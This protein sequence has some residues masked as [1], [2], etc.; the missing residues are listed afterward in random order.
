MPTTEQQQP[1][2]AVIAWMRADPDR[3]GAA[4]VLAGLGLIN[5]AGSATHV[6]QVGAYPDVGVR[7][8]MVW[9]VAG[10]L[11]VLA[12]YAAWEMR[13]R[14]DWRRIIPALVLLLAVAFII[15]ANLAAADPHSWAAQLPWAEAFAVAPPISFL[16]VAAIAETRGWQRAGRRPRTATARQRPEEP[17]ATTRQRRQATRG[18]PTDARP[19]PPARGRP[20]RSADDHG[21]QSLTVEPSD[22]DR[23]HTIL[24]WLSQGHDEKTIRSRGPAILGVSESTIKRELRGVSARDTDHRDRPSDRRP[25]PINASAA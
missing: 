17:K 4:V 11:E 6:L 7:G 15:L 10:S 5:L 24:R 18:A 14:S 8:W 3:T 16:S 22:K 9:T 1:L 19:S 23:T 25:E 21:P 12:A 13:R 20:R 2:T